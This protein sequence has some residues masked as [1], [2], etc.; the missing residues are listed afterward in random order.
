MQPALPLL[1]EQAGIPPLLA[2]L[3]L[4]LDRVEYRVS[5]NAVE[6]P[7]LYDRDLMPNQETFA[8]AA[9]AAAAAPTEQDKYAQI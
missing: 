3:F 2:H 5:S 8:T 4:Y 6:P 7:Y 1:L 9:A